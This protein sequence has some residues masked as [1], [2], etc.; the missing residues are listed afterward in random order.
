[1]H[2]LIDDPGYD[3]IEKDLR[4]RLDALRKQYKVPEQEM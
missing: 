4:K 1:M 2:N 3:K